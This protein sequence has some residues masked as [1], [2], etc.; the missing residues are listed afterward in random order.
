MVKQ[1]GYGGGKSGRKVLDVGTNN[2]TRRRRMITLCKAAVERSCNIL[3]YMQ[4]YLLSTYWDTDGSTFEHPDEKSLPN[5]YV[6]CRW[7]SFCVK[8]LRLF[9][10]Q[11]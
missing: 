4:Y 3:V 6:F 1:S 2:E 11:A 10:Y 7:T 8:P 9:G 5:S